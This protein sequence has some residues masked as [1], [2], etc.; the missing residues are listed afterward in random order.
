M[1]Y[2]SRTDRCLGQ[3]M[4][5]HVSERLVRQMTNP[6]PEQKTN[7]RNPISSIVKHQM[8]FDHQ[9]DP[10]QAFQVTLRYRDQGCWPFAR[11][12]RSADWNYQNVCKH[13]VTPLLL[14]SK[15]SLSLSISCVF[16]CVAPCLI[17][18]SVY[19]LHERLWRLGENIALNNSYR[20]PFYSVWSGGLSVK[21]SLKLNFW[22]KISGRCFAVECK[23]R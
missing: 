8:F 14:T 2:I 18:T 4:R 19:T 20:R 6:C 11:V 9:A 17:L 12:Y 22:F 10:G 7:T 16:H 1:T 3:R 23:L 13:C 15:L 5:E 21:N